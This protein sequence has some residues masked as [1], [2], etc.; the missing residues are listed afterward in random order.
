MRFSGFLDISLKN[1]LQTLLN[2]MQKKKKIVKCFRRKFPPGH[3][4]P[5]LELSANLMQVTRFI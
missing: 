5:A 4:P 3:F 1:F 2:R